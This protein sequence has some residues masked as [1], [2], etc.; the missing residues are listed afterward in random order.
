M[1]AFIQKKRKLQF[2]P[3]ALG[4]PA[5]RRGLRPDSP[6]LSPVRPKRVRNLSRVW[7]G[8]CGPDVWEGAGVQVGAVGEKAPVRA[9]NKSA[10]ERGTR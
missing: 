10:K 4:P 7:N 6:A 2:L 8:V 1:L 5:R 3:P 9:V